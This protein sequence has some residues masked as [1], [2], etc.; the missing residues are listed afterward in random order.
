MSPLPPAST[1]RYLC[2]CG[3]EC[4]VSIIRSWIFVTCTNQ[5][6]KDFGVQQLATYKKHTP[7]RPEVKI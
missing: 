3:K 1:P 5:K 6:C 2:Y 7:I 4:T